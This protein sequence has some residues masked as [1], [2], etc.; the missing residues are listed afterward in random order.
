MQWK[1]GVLPTSMEVGIELYLEHNNHPYKNATWAPYCGE[2]TKFF[3]GMNWLYIRELDISINNEIRQPAFYTQI[4]GIKESC[5][6]QEMQLKAEEAGIDFIMI[7][8]VN[9]IICCYISTFSTDG[10]RPKYCE[11][12]SLSTKI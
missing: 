3:G 11:S 12:P 1:T 4:E 7:R 10:L 8:M 2:K 5:I 9:L 6:D